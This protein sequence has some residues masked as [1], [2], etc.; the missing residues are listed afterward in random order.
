MA[1]AGVGDGEKSTRIQKAPEAK[2]AES[3]RKASSPP[4]VKAP[5]K[6]VRDPNWKPTWSLEKRS[7]NVDILTE[8]M[9]IGPIKTDGRAAHHIVQ[10]GNNKDASFQKARDLLLTHQIDINEP[11]NGVALQSNKPG[12]R[13]NPGLR[14][15]KG[16]VAKD[17]HL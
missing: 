15:H 6:H 13:I 4:E 8:R 11:A 17:D 16:D 3:S 1:A 9:G 2:K 5:V 7:R 12:A 14:I 10:A